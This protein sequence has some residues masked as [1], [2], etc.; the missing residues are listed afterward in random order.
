MW[1]EKETN[2]VLNINKNNE[3][4][5]ELSTKKSLKKKKKKKKKWF[6]L[7]VE[8]KLVSSSLKNSVMDS[9]RSV[10][11]S[12]RSQFFCWSPISPLSFLCYSGLF[13]VHQLWLVSLLSSHLYFLFSFTFT[14][15][16]GEMAELIVVNNFLLT[17][18]NSVLLARTEWSI[19]IAMIQRILCVLFSRTFSR[20]LYHLSL[21]L[22]LAQFAQLIT[23]PTQSYLFL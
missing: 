3:L 15:W 7:K 13:K 4:R 19:C 11:W 5:I 6:P 23:F 2:K 20:T 14:L 10:L 18:S 12:G 9:R 16:S 1:N 22:T 8:R 21:W 17:K